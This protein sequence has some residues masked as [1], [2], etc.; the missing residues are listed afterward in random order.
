MAVFRDANARCQAY[1]IGTAY[2]TGTTTNL[3]ALLLKWLGDSTQ[4][5][6]TTQSA[7]QRFQALLT[8]AANK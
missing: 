8:N 3:N 2:P 4:A 5:G 6:A 1:L 7:T